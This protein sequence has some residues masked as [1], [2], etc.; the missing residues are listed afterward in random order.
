M[1]SRKATTISSTPMAIEA[2]PSKTGEPV[3]CS[4]SRP[5]A[6]S[7]SPMT[8]AVSSNSAALTVVSRLVLTC[9]RV[10]VFERCASPRS[11]P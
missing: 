4:S 11:W 9:S 8:A 1:P 7:A 2:P 6:A 10:C 5:P 3:I